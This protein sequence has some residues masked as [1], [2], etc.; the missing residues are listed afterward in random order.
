[1][2]TYN[3][4]IEA[5]VRET[6]DV[7]DKILKQIREQT[8]Q[9]GLPAISVKPVE[10]RFLQFLIAAYGAVLAV[11][12]GTLGGYNGTWIARGLPHD[13]R[14]ITLEQD[15]HH[16][17]VAGEHFRLAGVDARTEIHV[18]DAHTLLRS[19]SGEGPFDF[20]FIDAEKGGYPA[21]LDWA[22]ANMRPGGVIAAHNVFRHGDIVDPHQRP[23]HQDNASLQP[24]SCTGITTP[25]A[26]VSCGRWVGDCAY[27]V[28]IRWRLSAG[29]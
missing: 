14:L 1:M 5:Y 3:A 19:L 29:R 25:V 9:K 13:G 28:V 6:F 4:A 18:G 22:L 11:E 7:E 10:G 20:M 16:A 21:Y 17:A 26:R 23:A 12:I 2:P 27:S 15:A 8:P 24:T